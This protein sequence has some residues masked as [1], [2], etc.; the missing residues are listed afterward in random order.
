MAVVLKQFL[1]CGIRRIIRFC[2]SIASSNFAGSMKKGGIDRVGPNVYGVFVTK[3]HLASESIGPEHEHGEMNAKVISSILAALG[4]LTAG[5][6]ANNP[7]TAALTAGGNTTVAICFPTGANSTA[8]NFSNYS[9]NGGTVTI[10]P[11]ATL[12]A[13][14]QTVLLEVASLTGGA[15]QLDIADGVIQTC[16]GGVISGVSLSG[17]VENRFTLADVGAPSIAGQAFSCGVG[18]LGLIAGGNLSESQSDHLTFAYETVTGD[19]DRKAQLASLSTSDATDA[20][21]QSGLMVRAS[22]DPNDLAL[23]FLA[24][25]PVGD[26]SIRSLVRADYQQP[27]DEVDRAYGGVASNLPN[28]W[29]RLKRSGNSFQMFV[30][31]DGVNWSMAAR[32]WQEF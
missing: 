13:D 28:Q 26:N 12:L 22:L 23:K 6:R 9:L 10:I 25:S 30:G 14:N 17:T 24:T 16:S 32:R 21:A 3:P 31:I 5:T 19:F 2:R 15:F 27:E 4:C 20:F 18:K 11:P 7:T 29:L 1:G 8:A